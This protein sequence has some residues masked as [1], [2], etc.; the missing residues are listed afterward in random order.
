MRQIVLSLL[1]GVMINYAIADEKWMAKRYSD[2]IDD[3]V[4]YTFTIESE[5]A[6]SNETMTLQ[7]RHKMIIDKNES[8]FSDVVMIGIHEGTLNEETKITIRFDKEKAYTE[9]WSVNSRNNTLFSLRTK[10]RIFKFLNCGKLAIRINNRYTEM[11]AVFDISGLKAVLAK[12]N[13]STIEWFDPNYA[14]DLNVEKIL[15]DLY[16][17]NGVI[18]DMI[19]ARNNYWRYV[20]L[21]YCDYFGKDIELKNKLHD[22]IDIAKNYTIE[23]PTIQEFYKDYDLTESYYVNLGF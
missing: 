5:P 14:Y 9:K 2:P 12:N 10:Y 4:S 8:E 15:L 11:T 21:N 6:E 13:L 16:R 22:I 7:I 1:L 23:M 19:P 17:Q 20:I 18:L 3:V